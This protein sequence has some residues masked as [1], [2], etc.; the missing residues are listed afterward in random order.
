MCAFFFQFF[1]LI[2][3]LYALI[4]TNRFV[5]LA[6]R[7]E[8]WVW[9]FETFS[10]FLIRFFLHYGWWN[11]GNWSTLLSICMK[12]QGNNILKL[13][14]FY[15]G[16]LALVF[17]EVSFHLFTLRTLN[18]ISYRIFVLLLFIVIKFSVHRGYKTNIAHSS[19]VF[20]F[21]HEFVLLLKLVS[22]VYA[23][24]LCWI[25]LII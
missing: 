6:N 12:L 1:F 9:E 21:L 7:L 22:T 17:S 15:V 10:G 8:F 19:F 16:F 5:M 24:G 18:V 4:S 2:I 14:E 20:S 25:L 23:E 3:K 13:E 11:S